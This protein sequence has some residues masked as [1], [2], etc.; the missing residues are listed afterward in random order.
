MVA[1][2]ERRKTERNREIERRL[3]SV[4]ALRAAREKIALA[5]GDFPDINSLIRE[6]REG[7]ITDVG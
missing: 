3:A 5:H 2:R 1:S 4:E 7:V 6:T